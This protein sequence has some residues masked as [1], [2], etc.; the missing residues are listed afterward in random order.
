[1]KV[2]LLILVRIKPRVLAVLNVNEWV[3]MEPAL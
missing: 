2:R 3:M 1:M